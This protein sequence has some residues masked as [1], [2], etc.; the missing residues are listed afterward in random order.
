MLSMLQL[1][2]SVKHRMIEL[3]H[4]NLLVFLFLPEQNFQASLSLVYQH[5]Q[6][7][8]P[9]VQTSTHQQM[10][11]EPMHHQSQLRWG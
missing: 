5:R 11:V 2:K 8:R 7:Q 3:W 6:D 1:S 4:A 9:P 10:L